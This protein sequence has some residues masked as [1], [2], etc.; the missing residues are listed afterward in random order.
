M[1]KMMDQ[2][3]LDKDRELQELRQNHEVITRDSQ[4]ELRIM[5]DKVASLKKQLDD[6]ESLWND[7][8]ITNAQVRYTV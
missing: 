1:Q 8:E 6:K 7:L 3:T 4:D 5:T 2:L